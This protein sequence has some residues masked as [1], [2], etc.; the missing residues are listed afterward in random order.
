VISLGD[1]RALVVGLGG[2]GCPAAWV[3]ARAG[4]GSLTLADPDRVEVHN[5]HRQPLHG[6]SDI[7]RPKVDSAAERL[8]AAFPGVAIRKLPLAVGGHNAR[9]LFAEHDLVL[10]ATDDVETKLALS[11]TAVATGTPLIY[12]GAVGTEGQLLSVLPGGPCLRCLFEDPPEDAPT[13][14]QAGVL[15]TVVGAVGAMQ[16]LWGV[17][18]LEGR[19]VVGSLVRFDGLTC[20]QRQVT[21]RRAADCP[22]CGAT[23]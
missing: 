10:D 7:G 8:Q 12:A 14:A 23:A 4:V 15:G 20:S 21:V 13:C 1:K 17:R 22:A 16:G 3:L 11:D 6:S 2:L 18:A 9:G 5:L 19:P